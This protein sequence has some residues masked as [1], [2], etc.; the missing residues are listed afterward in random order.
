M[1]LS[2]GMWLLVPWANSQGR[3]EASSE[4]CGGV[5]VGEEKEE[6]TLKAAAVGGRTVADGK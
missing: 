6:R 1:N 5:E 2:H 4:F 3:Y